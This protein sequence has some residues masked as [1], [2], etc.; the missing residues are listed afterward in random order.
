MQWLRS[1]FANRFNKLRGEQGHLFQGKFKSLLVEDGDPWEC[2]AM[3]FLSI[4]C[5]R[6]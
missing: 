6:A 4:R 2:S 3:T 1:T 5:V